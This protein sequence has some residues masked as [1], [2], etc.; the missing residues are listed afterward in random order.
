MMRKVDEE[1]RF[2]LVGHRSSLAISVEAGK[3]KVDQSVTALSS[4]VDLLDVNSK[5]TSHKKK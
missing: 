1:S 3:P 5:S 2:V 4:R